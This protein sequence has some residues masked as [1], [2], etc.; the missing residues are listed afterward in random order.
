M[1]K[2]QYG[3]IVSWYGKRG[4]GMQLVAYYRGPEVSYMAVV[5][6]DALTND[7]G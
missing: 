6:P 7:R 5:H 2:Q 4:R 3:R 1:C